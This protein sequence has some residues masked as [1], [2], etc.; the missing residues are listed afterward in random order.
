[1]ASTFLSK[2]VILSYLG[3]MFDSCTYTFYLAS[4]RLSASS[5]TQSSAD[6]QLEDSK[7][8]RRHYLSSSNDA[9]SFEF[10]STVE[11]ALLLASHNSRG[12]V[13]VLC[14]LGKLT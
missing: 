13:S 3:K 12:P 9:L 10:C 4:P 5:D 2:T 8:E 14:S 11:M 1:M 6:T 7:L